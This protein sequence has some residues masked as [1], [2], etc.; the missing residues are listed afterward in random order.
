M[1]EAVIL[2]YNVQNLQFGREYFIPKPFDNRLITKVSSAVA[3]AAIESGVARK[4]ITDFDEYEHQLLDRMGRDERLVR[5]MQSRAKSTEKN[6][7]LK[8]RRIQCIESCP[9]SL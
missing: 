3:K 1:P 2:A 8:C 7:P 9:D 5:M 4:T 6:Y